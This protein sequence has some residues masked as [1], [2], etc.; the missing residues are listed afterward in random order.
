MEGLRGCCETEICILIGCGSATLLGFFAASSLHSDTQPDSDGIFQK[1]RHFSSLFECFHLM[2]AA[3]SELRC[4]A[5]LCL[6]VSPQ[7]AS[8]TLAAGKQKSVQKKKKID[9]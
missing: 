5:T 8:T 7:I 9:K 6:H 1:R 2:N 3:A 4:A